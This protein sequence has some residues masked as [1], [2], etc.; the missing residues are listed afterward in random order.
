V[1]VYDKQYICVS[2]CNCFDVSRANT[3]KITVFGGGGYPYL[4]PACAGVLEHKWS[5]LGLLK[6]AFNAENFIFMLSWST[7][8][9]SHIVANHFYKM[10]ASAKNCKNSLKTHISRVQGCSKSLMIINR[11]SPSTVLIMISSMFLPICN[12]F[13]TVPANSGKTPFRGRDTSFD[14][15]VRGKSGPSLKGTKFCHARQTRVPWQPIVNT[16]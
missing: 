7:S 14:A 12:R 13:Y 16:S 2:I 9:S 4:T 6:S 8:I 1:L 15:L 10:C 11:Q 3:G 5:A